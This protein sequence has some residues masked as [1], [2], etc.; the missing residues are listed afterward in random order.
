MNNLDKHYNK[1]AKWW[2]DQHIDSQY[3]LWQLQ[4]AIQLTENK[5]KALDIG[6]GAGGRM[7]YLLQKNN[8]KVTGVDFSQEMIKIA[9]QNHPKTSFYVAD[10]CTWQTNEKFDLIIAWDSLFHLPLAEHENVIPKICSWLN[11]GGVFMYTF[12]DAIGEHLSKWHD[13][14][15]YYSSI[16]ITKNLK[17]ISDSNCECKHLELDQF[18]ESHVFVIVKKL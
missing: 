1:I 8:F 16:G 6:C 12:G 9:Q 10:I 17:L 2:N 15:F 11:S 7:I 13:E 3:G 4:K 18:P 14:D 5:N